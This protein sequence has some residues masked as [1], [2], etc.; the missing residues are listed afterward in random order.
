MAAIA[1]LN[2]SDM[3]GT[4]YPKSPNDGSPWYDQTARIDRVY[5]DTIKAW[6]SRDNFQSVL[7]A[8]GGGFWD[9]FRGAINPQW[10]LLKGSDGAAAYPVVAGNDRVDLVT[11]AAGTGIAADGCMLCSIALGNIADRTNGKKIVIPFKMKISA[12]TTVRYWIGLSD[13]NALEQSASLSATTYTTVATDAALVLFDTAAT[14]DTIRLVGV[15]NDVD[16]TH[17]DTSLAPTADTYETW[18]LEVDASTGDVEFFRNSTSLGTLPACLRTS[19]PVYFVAGVVPTTTS[20][21][22]LSLDFA[23][24]H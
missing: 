15:K 19:V 7:S 14:T 24:V 10:T 11:A 6:V 13:S 12:I 1:S 22:T 16:A 9:D 5:D 2:G 20:A 18:R 8:G 21:R 17:L 4:A 3:S 23:G